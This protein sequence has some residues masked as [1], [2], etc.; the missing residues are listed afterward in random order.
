MTRIL[1]V[2]VMVKTCQMPKFDRLFVRV[3]A[4]CSVALT[5]CMCIHIQ[6]INA[7]V[8][9]DLWDNNVNVQRSGVSTKSCP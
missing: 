9:C 2:L 6:K 3:G 1:K 5:Y 4:R 8:I 7:T